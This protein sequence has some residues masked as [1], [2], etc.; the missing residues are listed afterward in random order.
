MKINKDKHKA[1]YL[2][3]NDARH[4]YMLEADW[5][6]NSSAEK[7]LSILMDNKLTIKQQHLIAK[8][9]TASWAVL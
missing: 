1:L 3:R 6:E 7:D 9:P 5:L 8:W 2:G 4:Q